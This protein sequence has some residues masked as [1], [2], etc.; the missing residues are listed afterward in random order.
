MKNRLA[1]IQYLDALSVQVGHRVR[2]KPYDEL[3]KVKADADQITVLV[4]RVSVRELR[5]QTQFQ[6][7]ELD[8]IQFSRSVSGSWQVLE[9]RV[10]D[11]DFRPYV[12]QEFGEVRSTEELAAR[13]ADE[14][15]AYRCGRG[16][17]PMDSYQRKLQ[18]YVGGVDSWRTDK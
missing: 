1:D 18:G 3:V 8:L 16:R 6:S 4:R 14:K 12:C 15:L 2:L 11:P 9:T 17:F 5:Y 10:P 13:R 7:A